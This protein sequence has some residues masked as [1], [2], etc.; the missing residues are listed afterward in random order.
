MDKE[1][2]KKFYF[3]GASK[4]SF[5]SIKTQHSNTTDNTN[6][7]KSHS[8]VDIDVS[9]VGVDAAGCVTSM[10]CGQGQEHSGNE[11]TMSVR[12]GAINHNFSAISSIEKSISGKL[13]SPAAAGHINSIRSIALQ[14]LLTSRG[15][16]R[17][18]TDNS[19]VS[20]HSTTFHSSG[21]QQVTDKR[22]T[23]RNEKKAHKV[24]TET[25]SSEYFTFLRKQQELTKSHSRIEKAIQLFESVR[26]DYQEDIQK[27]RIHC[28]DILHEIETTND[29]KLHSKY[30]T[31]QLIKDCDLSLQSS[32]VVS[33]VEPDMSGISAVVDYLTNLTDH[34]KNNPVFAPYNLMVG[35]SL[36]Q[37]ALLQV[38]MKESNCDF[39]DLARTLDTLLDHLKGCCELSLTEAL[40]S[41]N[42]SNI[43]SNS[44]NVE[45][46]CEKRKAAIEDGEVNI[47]EKLCYDIIDKYE[48]IEGEVICKGH[49]LDKAFED[50]IMITEAQQKNYKATDIPLENIRVLQSQLRTRCESDIKKICALKK[51][52]AEVEAATSAKVSKNREA[53]DKVLSSN[54]ER[55]VAVYTAMKELEDEMKRL[56]KER[57]REFQRRL[58]DKEKEEDRKAEYAKFCETIDSQ[59]DLLERTIKNADIMTH[60]TDVI[61]EVIKNGFTNISDELFDRRELLKNIRVDTHKEHVEVFRALLVE[62]GEIIYRKERMIEEVDKKIQQAHIQQELL[63][64]TFNPK[65]RKFGD[66]K[67]SLLTSRDDLKGDV[68]HLKSRA[69]NALNCFQYSEEALREAGIDFIHPVTDQQHHTLAM[70]AKMIEYKAMMA[71]HYKGTSV[72]MEEIVGLQH[73]VTCAKDAMDSF[74]ISTIGAGSRYNTK[75][76]C[77][78]RIKF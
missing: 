52:I 40:I 17:N 6:E 20:K 4:F 69:E 25:V 28:L 16:S 3:S 55:L 68:E 49:T 42:E 8:D 38:S 54:E 48:F 74:N 5:P 72:L 34:Y 41:D 36:E 31:S 67:K 27:A 50:T 22:G 32:E 30:D 73:E 11:D 59:M 71:G 70:K 60:A 77:Q 18:D 13:T 10:T 58:V 75:T 9:A 44:A 51:R 53:S 45:D 37:L 66:M 39:S 24:S 7:R 43:A 26:Q 15:G 1:A 57:Y 2:I 14:N 64:E 29:W 35:H 46:M 33:D 56:E 61:Q 76:T 47:A 63:A 12:I 21:S 78:K 23:V 19:D 65:A 62:L